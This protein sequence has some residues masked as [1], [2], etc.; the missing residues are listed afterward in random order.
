MSRIRPPILASLAACSILLA[1]AD[2][3]HATP[4]TSA[5]N[6]PFSVHSPGGVNMATGELILVLEPDLDLGGPMPL[7]FG[8]YYASFLARE[9]VTSG[10]LGPNWLGT[11]DVHLSITGSNATF[12]TNRG[13]AIRFTQNPVG[14]WDLTS[15]TYANFKLDI[16]GGKWRITDPI[17]GNLYFFDGT[18]WLLTLIQDGHGTTLGLVYGVGSNLLSQVSDGLGRQLNFSYDAGGH[19][20]QVSDGLRYVSYAYTGGLLTGMTDAAGH[21]WTY[22]Y[23]APP[24]PDF[25]ALVA[26]TEPLGNTPMTQSYDGFGRV[27]SQLDALSH[28]ASYSYDLPTGNMFT[29]PLGESWHYQHDALGRLTGITDPAGGP[30]SYSYDSQGRLASMSRP[31]GDVTSFVYDGGS[32]FLSTLTLG[33]G[34]AFHFTYSS[35]LFGSAKFW[36]LASETFAD[37]AIE[38]YARDGLGNLTNLTD[39]GGFHWTATY[40]SRG[41]VLTS[42]NPAGG[43]TTN[44]Y[45]FAARLATRRDN[46]GN[47]AAYG[48]DGLG[49][50]T[51]VTWPGGATRSYAYDNLDRLTLLTDE[52]GKP[53]GE[54]YDANGRPLSKTDPLGETTNYAYDGLDRRIQITDPLGHTRSEAYDPDG[55]L[56]HETD[57]SGRVTHYQ[58]DGLN[59]L[60]GIQDPAGGADQFGYDANDRMTSE[61]DPLGHSTGYSYDA[62]DR[63]THMTD[64]VGAGF[65]YS[66]D[67][68]GRLLS[69]TGPLGHSHTFGYDPRGLLTSFVNGTS[70]TDFPRTPLGEISQLTD[71]NHDAWPYAYDAQGRMTSS[72]D[73]LGRT[74]TYAYDGR[75]RVAHV[76][77]A[78]G[79]VQQIDYDGVGNVTMQSF[80]DT[81]FTYA[82]DD[83]N[84][85]LTT[86]GA[87]FMYDAAGRIVNSNGF[88]S[89]RDGEGR[90]LSEMFAPGKA[91][92]YSYDSRG[93]L[94][95]V[96]DWMSGTTSFS[97]DAA[98]RLT[99]VT[100]ANGTTGTYAYDNA[101]RV[102]SKVEVGPGPIGI[103]SI[104]ITRDA[105]G[106][107]TTIG[108]GQP[109][110]PTAGTPPIG[111]FSYDAASQVNGVGH[112]PL[113]RTTSDG[114]R[115]LVWDP[116]SRLQHYTAS[117]ES[118]TFTADAFG[119]MQ[120]STAGTQTA[121]RAWNYGHTVPGVDDMEVDL[122][123]RL[124]YFVRTQ[125]G[126]LL[127]S[128]DDATGARSFY[129]YDEQ[130]NTSFLTDDAGALVAKYAYG[131]FGGVTTEPGGP[132]RPMPD[133]PFMFGA[134]QGMMALGSSGLWA[135]GPLIYDDRTLRTISGNTTR[136]G[137]AEIF[138]NDAIVTIGDPNVFALNQ[139]QLSQSGTFMHELG[140]NLNLF[141]GGA[142]SPPPPRGVALAVPPWPWNKFASFGP[143]A[144]AAGVL[145][146]P[147]PRMSGVSEMMGNDAIVA[148]GDPGIRV[149]DLLDAGVLMHELGHTLGLSHGGPVKDPVFDPRPKL[150]YHYSELGHVNH[151]SAEDP[152]YQY[153][154]IP[155]SDNDGLN[156]AWEASEANSCGIDNDCEGVVDYIDGD[157]DQPIVTPPGDA[158]RFPRRRPQNYDGNYIFD[159]T[160][161]KAHL[162]RLASP[163]VT[164]APC[165]WCPR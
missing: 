88:Q 62:L 155:D 39:R 52:R 164:S 17:E 14:N 25:G 147:L 107:A 36:D 133:N 40:N 1:A 79:T 122:P 131:P 108:R 160:D 117:T 110:M 2:L 157:P 11:Y 68:M 32:G 138:G 27:V 7:R 15:P 99:G 137:M 21:P 119:S 13:E 84:R 64:P 98:R 103:S 82:Y 22:A 116:A 149:A 73:P 59:R 49:R 92:N 6:L 90:V 47:T 136:S 161:P 37:G 50:L 20:T 142:G 141:H 111:D 38:S 57:R 56:D 69:E 135:M 115:T 78:D 159:P 95:Q 114:A 105:L 4:I 89:T 23:Q 48:Y 93:L 29:D 28:L 55:R 77:R 60:I 81:V 63:V 101:G 156:N 19:L 113:G 31:L 91:V 72:A 61:Q 102:I 85:L 86:N 97:Y 3:V 53:W 83:A 144:T 67:A 163:P 42:T 128:V 127:Y 41:Q 46:A 33:D 125:G 30:S 132:L 71:P 26:V 120:N 153:G 74:N 118:P 35:H 130:G 146:D 140:H 76:G 126:H 34:S 80:A 145:Q 66:Y 162:R 158:F 5:A 124:Q 70:E 10:P 129:H 75:D 154:G 106:R 150:R 104:S 65:D 151:V 45:D 123:H 8:R 44:T 43:V 54:T 58:Y 134:S 94:S 16:V 51:Q 18:T 100:R 165:L 9:G 121:Q 109:L 96:Q 143:C 139:K 24:E 112:D 12:V 148:I 152:R 87:S